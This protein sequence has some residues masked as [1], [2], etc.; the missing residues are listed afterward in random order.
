MEF[1]EG[2]GEEKGD[3]EHPIVNVNMVEIVHDMS[4]KQFSKRPISTTIFFLR[5]RW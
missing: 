2:A 1:D 3:K 4:W 5:L